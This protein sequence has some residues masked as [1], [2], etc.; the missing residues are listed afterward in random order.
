MSGLV[1]GGVA[2][3]DVKLDGVSRSKADLLCEHKASFPMSFIYETRK[4]ISLLFPAAHVLQTLPIPLQPA[5]LNP[6][7]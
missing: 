4:S 7:F 2:Y 6:K 3:G 1:E 5:V